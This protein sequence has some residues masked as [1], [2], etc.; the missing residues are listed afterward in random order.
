MEFESFDIWFFHP[1]EYVDDDAG[2]AVCIEVDFL[3][4]WDLADFA[5]LNVSTLLINKCGSVSALT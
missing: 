4:I 3:I 1:F 2:E 5:A